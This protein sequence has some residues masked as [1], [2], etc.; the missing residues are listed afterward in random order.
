[1]W[2]IELRF[3]VGQEIENYG[4]TRDLFLLCCCDAAFCW[5]AGFEIG[6]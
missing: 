4:F 1:M 6:I 3:G 5:E 2:L